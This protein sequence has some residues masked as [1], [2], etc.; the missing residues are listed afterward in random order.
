MKILVL[1]LRGNW[2]GSFPAAVEVAGRFL[3][4]GKLIVT[5][6][7]HVKDENRK[8][9]AKF[10]GA[11]N[12][13]LVVLVD[14]ETASA[15]EVVAGA[16]KDHKRAKL[17]GQPTFGKGSI[18][19][20]LNLETWRAGGVRITLAKFVSPLGNTFHLLGV[21]PDYLEERNPLSMSD[22]QLQAAVGVAVQLNPMQQ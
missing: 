11:L 9:T 8:Y 5:T 15:A 6:K 22:Q 7:S 21:T 17:V 20:V 1:D 2:G 19:T 3:P 18:Q 16:L 14:G 12:I 4:E 13:P 10:P